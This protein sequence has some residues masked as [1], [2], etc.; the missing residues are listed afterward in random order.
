MALVPHLGMSVPIQVFLDSTR[1]GNAGAV[2]VIGTTNRLESMDPALRR[3]GRFDR[4]VGKTIPSVTPPDTLQVEI[5]IPNA[6]QRYDILS[7]LLISQ[8][9]TA[10]PVYIMGAVLI[11]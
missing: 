4:E 5:G 7:S 1:G 10:Q 6:D 9:V 3:P 8:A 2:F 11:I